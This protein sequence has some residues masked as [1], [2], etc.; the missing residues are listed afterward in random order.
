MRR[1]LFWLAVVA[2]TAVL[3]QI[4]THWF[5]DWHWFQQVLG[6]K[7]SKSYDAATSPWYNWH[8]GAGSD[9][10]ELAII[11]LVV[12]AVRHHNCH[13]KGC[14]W[15]GRRVEGTPYVACPMHHPAHTGAKRGVSVEEIHKAFHGRRK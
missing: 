14:P 10:Q 5:A 9:L 1:Y 15:L 13:V 8:S 2:A 4:L 6:I 3:A 12:G 7:G 11:G